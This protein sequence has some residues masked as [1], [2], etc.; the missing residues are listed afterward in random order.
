MIRLQ[1]EEYCHNCP[2]FEPVAEKE[3][4]TLTDSFSLNEYRK[5]ETFVKCEYAAR[6]AC[7]YENHL[8]KE[9]AK[10]HD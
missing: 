1:V 10:N 6:C 3:T 9:A 7:M 2:D 5:N 8:K 4:Y